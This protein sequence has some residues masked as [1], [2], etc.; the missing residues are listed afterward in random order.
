MG[1][2]IVVQTFSATAHLLLDAK[3]RHSQSCVV[4]TLQMM[5]LSFTANEAR[6]LGKAVSAMI[7]YSGQLGKPSA[8]K[9]GSQGGIWSYCG[10]RWKRMIPYAGGFVNVKTYKVVFNNN[11]RVAE[12]S[13]TDSGDAMSDVDGPSGS[14]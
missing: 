7:A 6:E 5:Q 13:V 14:W 2:K 4:A 12:H 11:G 8:R 9:T 3:L 1:G 10:E